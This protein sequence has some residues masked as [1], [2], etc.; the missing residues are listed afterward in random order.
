MSVGIVNDFSIKRIFVILVLGAG[1]IYDTTQ[2]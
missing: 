2:I 1:V